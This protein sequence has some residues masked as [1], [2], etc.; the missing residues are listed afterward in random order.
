LVGDLLVEGLSPR[1]RWALPFN[2]LPASLSRPLHWLARSVFRALHSLRFDIY[3]A[4]CRRTKVADLRR[5][6]RSWYSQN[7]EDGILRIIFEKIDVTNRFCVEFG[8]E[9]GRECNTRYLLEKAGWSGLRMDGGSY[10][11]Y[12]GQVHQEFITAENI[13]SLFAKYAVPKQ[14]DLLSIDIDGN[15]YWVWRAVEGYSP[16]VVVIEYNASLLPHESKTIR[17][18]PGFRWDG[19][20]YFGAS[21]LALAKLGRVKGYTLIGCDSQGV[22]AFFVRNDLVGNRFC[23]RSVEQ[24]YRRPQYGQVVH[25]KCIGHRPTPKI[26]EM[27]E[28]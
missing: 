18:D 3:W 8:V 4:L 6:E 5:F 12:F 1:R 20:N 11:A 15:D 22:N 16:R 10:S 13:C 25:G 26:S 24:L 14:F 28:I 21:L 23:E 9:D 2:H 19:S 7:G 27:V 17:Y